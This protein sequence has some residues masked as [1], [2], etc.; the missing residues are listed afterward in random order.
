M[1]KAKVYYTKNITPDGLNKIY[2]ALGVELKGNIGIKVSTGERGSKGY[3]KAD[4]IKPFVDRLNGTIVEC[5]TAYPGA[6]NKAE[7]HLEVAEEHGFTAMG[8]GVEILD[9][10]GE[11]KIPVNKGKHLKYDII[12]KAMTKYDSFVNL[13]HGKGHAMGGFGAN[14]KNQSIGFASRNGKAYIHRDRKSV[15]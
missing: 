3:L 14:L 12:G 10:L 5:N 7:E 4:L 9:G 1:E 11:F 2:D 8:Q 6:R 13:A 15:V